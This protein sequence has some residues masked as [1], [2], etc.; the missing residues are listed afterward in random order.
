MRLI[1]AV[2][3]AVSDLERIGM[4]RQHDPVRTAAGGRGSLR[5]SV[6]VRYIGNHAQH[7]ARATP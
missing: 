5:V 7:A 6:E 1:I 3:K 2:T 4:N